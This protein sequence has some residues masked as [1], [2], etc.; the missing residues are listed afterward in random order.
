M[1]NGCR[2]EAVPGGGSVSLRSVFQMAAVRTGDAMGV[3]YPS[4]LQALLW[5]RDL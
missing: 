1:N 4:T 2:T 5:P 3:F